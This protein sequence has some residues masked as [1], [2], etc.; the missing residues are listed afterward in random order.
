MTAE[1]ESVPGQ[2]TA[3]SI[4]RESEGELP[5]Q[6]HSLVL[7]GSQCYSLGRQQDP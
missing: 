1:N 2:V 5:R 7:M 4:Q 6:Q 3:L